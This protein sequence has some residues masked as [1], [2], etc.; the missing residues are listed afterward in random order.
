MTTTKLLTPS[1]KQ[2][3]QDHGISKETFQP[4][5]ALL[6]EPYIP[7]NY[8][9]AVSCPESEKWK[10]AI[11]DEYNSII[12]NK[13][14]EIVPLPKNRKAIKGKW[15]LDFKPAHKGAAARYKARFV[16]CGYAQLYGIDYFA[17]YSPVVKHYFIRLLAI[18]AAKDLEMVYLDIK[19]TFLY[20]ELKEEIYML[21]PE[22]YALPGR[23]DEVCKLQCLYRL[24]QSSRCWFEK[25]EY[26]ITKF[27]FTHC[28]SD[29]CVYYRFGP[30]G[31]YTILI[32]YVDDGLLCSNR[33]ASID[34]TLHY[35][36]T[37]F[38]VHGPRRT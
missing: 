19:T 31:E 15:V 36:R 20:G 2:H 38:Q 26:F 24:K 11:Q 14:W 37:Y 13:T 9:D 30:D 6:L 33:T 4:A 18:A 8:N 10:A 3:S 21:Q 34:A 16:A 1:L 23:E 32:I 35:L 29:P 22:G 28:Q 12:E 7:I 25:L 27:G 5:N 17:T